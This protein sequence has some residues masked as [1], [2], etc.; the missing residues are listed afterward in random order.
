MNK[1]AAIVGLAVLPCLPVQ[2]DHWQGHEQ[3]ER[4]LWGTYT[5]GP[6]RSILSPRAGKPR[7]RADGALNPRTGE[8]YAPAGPSG[9]IDTETGEFYP[10]TGPGFTN[11]KTGE[12]YPAPESSVAPYCGEDDDC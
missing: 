11:P 2:A 4:K 10:K 5:P 12:F 7:H 6:T 8:Y 3:W 1:L 9:V